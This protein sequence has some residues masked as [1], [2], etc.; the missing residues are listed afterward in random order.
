MSAHWAWI[1][2]H[3]ADLSDWCATIFEYGETAWREYRSAAWYVDRLRREG[4][5]VEEG[6]GGMPTAFCAHW[7]NGPGPT[8][9]MYAE[10]DGIPG[11]CQAASTREEPRTGLTTRA[12]G[13]TDPHSALGI[14]ALGALLATKAAMQHHGIP[15]TLRFT[16]EPAEK[17]RGSKP[18]HAAAGYYDGL[19]AAL[20]FHPYY[21]D[22]L[23][24]T[25]RWDTHCGA[26]FSMVYRFRCDA[27]HLWQGGRLTSSRPTSSARRSGDPHPTPPIPQA[28][29]DVRAPGAQDALVQMYQSARLTRDAMLP[30]RGGWSISE[31]I[32]AAGQATADNLPETRADLQYMIRTSTV[33]EAETVTA[34]LDTLAEAAAASTGCSWEKIWVSKS[35]PGLANHAIAQ[36]TWDA[37]QAAGPPRWSEAAHRLMAEVQANATGEATTYAPNTALETLTDPQEAEAILRRDL[38]PSQSN[39]TSDDYTEMT[40]H[41]PTARLYIARPTLTGGPYPPWTMNAL[42][43]LPACIDPTILTAART[44]SQAALR[45]LQDDEARGAASDEFHRRTSENP[46][47]PLCD[48]APPIDLDWPEYADT[49]R[50]RIWT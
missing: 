44:L 30:H 50:G 6:S 3:R 35:R 2:A 39:S 12:G 15:G 13:H 23:C 38:P 32:L 24:N 28:H 37:L 29:S 41:A 10:Y 45:L 31:A 27:P 43:G 34:R 19:D 22:P 18:I 46:I 47:P 25:V 42:G 4:F 16:G 26:A 48:Y 17:V 1:D 36:V 11:Q 7:S 49:P 8:I 40:W 14:G 21:M 5:D 9:L 33:E 20:S